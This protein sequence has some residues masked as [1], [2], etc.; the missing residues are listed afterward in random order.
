MIARVI[1]H[2]DCTY[3]V[4]RMVY[5]NAIEGRFELELCK[6]DQHQLPHPRTGGRYCDHYQQ[7]G[8]SCE[9]CFTIVPIGLLTIQR[10]YAKIEGSKQSD[11]KSD[12]NNAQLALW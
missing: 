5:K 11:Q 2:N 8:C 3:C 9:E 6:L 10:T 12:P 7:E 4:Y 1:H